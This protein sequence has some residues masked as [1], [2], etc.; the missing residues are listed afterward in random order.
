MR[1]R[2]RT[3][4]TGL[5]E[6][7][8]GIGWGP[9]RGVE[10]LAVVI[11]CS[12]IGA[13][14]I[15]PTAPAWIPVGDTQLLLTLT[16][17]AVGAAAAILAVVASR[18]LGDRRPAW[19]AAALLL[20]CV[21]LL[22]WTAVAPAAALALPERL[23]RLIVYATATTLL[24]LSVRPPQRGGAWGAGALTAVG[25][26]LAAGALALPAGP[27]ARWS[28]EG[29]LP[30][31]V[32]VLGWTAAA[33][34]FVVDGV[35]TRRTPWLRLGLGLLVLAGSQ[36]PPV[37]PTLPT[38][39]GELAF[40]GLQLVGL[41][42][43]MIGLAQCVQRALAALRAEQWQQQEELAA[44]ALQMDRV[45]ELAA[46]RDHELRNGLAGL[47]GITHLLNSDTDG[48]DHDR[49]KHAVLAELG[50]LHMILDGPG[51]D[52]DTAP[53]PDPV[54]D[55]RVEP[56]LSGLVTLRRL[57]GDQLRLQVQP[58]LLARGR[59]AVLAQ[60][61]TNLLAN[62]D[63]HAPGA[64][65]SVSARRGEG[66]IVIE[67]RDEGPG[68]PRGSEGGLFERGARDE[69]AG[70]SGLGLHISERLLSAEGGALA[71]R[72]AADPRGCVATVTVP[73][74]GADQVTGSRAMPS[75]AQPAR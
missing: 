4:V 37:V 39:S 36:L 20:F 50:R 41:M 55:Y 72:T 22:P 29:P 61:V 64:M 45:G 34:A 53:N 47:A 71:L 59:S 52:P 15:S 18:L 66:V 13:L 40:A 26:L 70:G 56:V 23:A 31:A 14:S 32:I 8:R 63:R 68:L 51:A 62:C 75:G 65:I 16:A 42:I 46:E 1:W 24:V 19:I 67:V 58:G 25:G 73:R 35:R 9:R 48:T 10:V 43:V 21:I 54:T 12:A 57:A 49:L 17:A 11:G 69:T 27:A 74:A 7:V 60:V 44:A 2:Y 28:V 33:L 38:A 6:A 3:A 5:A 30:V